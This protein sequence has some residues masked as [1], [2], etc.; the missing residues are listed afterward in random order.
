M[1]KNDIVTLTIDNISTD[2][3]GVAHIDGFP[4]FVPFTA[5]GDVID[6]K[7]VKVKSNLAYGIIDGMIS[8]SPDRVAVDCPVF[9]KCGGCAYRH[10]SY[11]AE[12]KI[13]EDNFYSTLRR[14]GHIECERHPILHSSIVDHYRNK[15]EF[16]VNETLDACLYSR[17]SHNTV[18]M[19]DDC[20]IQDPRITEAAHIVSNV[21]KDFSLMP[22]DE[23]TGKGTLRHI[24]IRSN[25]AGS[26]YICLVI[27]NT[28]LPDENKIVSELLSK[29]DN[30]D[31]ISINI[32]K[33]NT[34]VIIGKESRVIWGNPALDD[35][36]CNLP[37]NVYP[38]SF[39]QVNRSCTEVLYLKV[40]ELANIS[41]S[42]H[43]LDLY[44]GMGTIGLYACDKST[45][46][47][48]VEIVPE[49]V[50]TAKEISKKL[51]YKNAEFICG[52]AEKILSDILRS[53]IHYNVVITDPPRKG[54]S[55]STL[56]SILAMSPDR[57]VMVSCNPAT[58]ARDL[59]YLIDRGYTLEYAVPVDMFPRTVHVETV[60]ALSK[61]SEAKHHINIQVDMDELDLTAAESKATYEEIQAW[62]QEKYGFHVSYLNIAKTKR[63]CGIIERINYNLPK[64]DNS[65][66]PETPK[67][68]EDAIIDAFKHFQMI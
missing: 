4:V 36:L 34:N 25:H 62:V 22:Y 53:D 48:G 23:K 54:C 21:L 9:R 39:L 65:K 61:L 58:L 26:M 42:D 67:E 15:G 66:S 31:G 29:I 14:I 50:S 11:E 43:V 52:D 35:L 18:P 56:D 24:Y 8:P 33:Q 47:T 16:P 59:R 10:I 6:A 20:L 5:V 55:Q 44:C 41:S 1:K 13:K 64:S 3:N 2:G 63:K 28:Y 60:C 12:L 57:L 46:L 30:I 37:V 7:I 38:P 49:A 17:R 40:K 27:N 45:H 51:N 19:P 32:N 68:K